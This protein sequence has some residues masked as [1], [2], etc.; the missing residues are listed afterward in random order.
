[1]PEAVK[2]TDIDAERGDHV[3]VAGPG[4]DAHAEPR[5]ADQQE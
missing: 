5:V 4:A 1:M 2:P 3:A